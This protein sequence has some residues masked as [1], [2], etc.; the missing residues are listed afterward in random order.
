[1]QIEQAQYYETK[2]LIVASQKEMTGELLIHVILHKFTIK[3]SVK[4]A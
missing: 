1:M 2:D 3:A 4:I